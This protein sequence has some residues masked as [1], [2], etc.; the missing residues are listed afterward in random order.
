MINETIRKFDY[1]KTLL[2]E[3]SHWVV[4]LRPKQVTLGSLVLACK[5]EATVLRDVS[6]QGFAELKSVV[7]DLEAALRDAFS[8]DK[9]NYVLLMMVDK[10]VHFHVIPRYSS[11][12]E[13][14]GVEFEDPGWPKYPDLGHATDISSEQFAELLT[15]I[16]SHWPSS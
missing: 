5:E 15:A 13:V 7:G 9:I 1:P 16:K 10:Y 8:F 12:R 6:T 4:L 2:A 11:A 3:Y 14:N